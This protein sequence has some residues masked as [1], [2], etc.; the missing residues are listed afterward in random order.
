MSANPP[1]TPSES[2]LRWFGVI[3][4]VF[5][6]LVGGVVAWQT[7]SLRAG[8]ILAAIGLGLAGLYTAVRSIR[9]PLF[10]AWMALVTPFGLFV[11][12]VLLGA[13]YFVVLTPTALLM[14]AFGRD[15]LERRFED[16]TESYWRDEPPSR[17]PAAYFR[18]S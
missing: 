7:G 6:G 8:A 12:T 5:F 13:V 15:P 16:A 14:R 3:L 10:G 2:D 18:Q 9:R 11:S 4:L 17:D 1:G